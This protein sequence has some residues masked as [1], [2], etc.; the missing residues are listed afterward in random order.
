MRVLNWA[1]RQRVTVP[2][3]GTGVASRPGN[4]YFGHLLYGDDTAC[5][6]EINTRLLRGERL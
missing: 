1:G 6:I 2:D 4:F 5:P 3:T